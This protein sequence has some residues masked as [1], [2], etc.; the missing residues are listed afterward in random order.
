[1]A[2]D[3][4]V[5]DKADALLR[6]HAISAPDAGG[7]TGAVPVLTD[8]VDAGHAPQGELAREVFTRVMEEVE[9]RLAHDLEARLAQHLVPHVHATVA[10]ALADLRQ[11]LANAIGDAV[12]EALAKRQVK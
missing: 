7:D 6:R 4:E 8:L 2:S 3:K 10:A 9:G 12:N 1:M 11:E 5:L